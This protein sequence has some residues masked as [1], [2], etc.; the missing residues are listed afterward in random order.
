MIVNPK[1]IILGTANFDSR[2]GLDGVSV[3]KNKSNNILDYAK[4]KNIKYID[5]ST[6]Y[7][8]YKNLKK[9]LSIKN[10]SLSFKITKKDFKNLSSKQKTEVFVKNILKIFNK[11][12]IHYLF[13]H[14]T[15][16]LMSKKGTE[17]YKILKHF[18]KKNKIGK[19]GCS[20]YSNKEIIKILKYYPI[21]ILQIPLNIFDQR[22]ADRKIQEIIKKKQIE[23]HARSIFLQGLLFKKNI[24]KKKFGRFK[25]LSKWSKYIKENKLNPLIETFT[26]LLQKKFID[27]IVVGVKSKKELNQILNIKIN[28][29]RKNYQSFRSN[30]LDLIDPR[31]W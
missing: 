2:Y 15:K 4:S 12:K 18:Q 7:N 9:N 16:D 26:F 8:F 20:V 6:D 14:H 3:N 30:N 27:K 28:Y 17:V 23:I 19:I 24:S 10:I 13:F 21:N 31:K 5:I 29:K 25:A 22:F 1:K 11:K